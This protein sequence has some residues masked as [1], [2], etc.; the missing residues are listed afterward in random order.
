MFVTKNQIEERKA[1]MPRTR[2]YLATVYVRFDNAEREAQA[3][4]S[5]IEINVEQR[6]G[7]VGFF[8]DATQAGE[9]RTLVRELQQLDAE[10]HAEGK[11]D[12]IS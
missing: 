11:R 7:V 6:G 2:S 10:T 5:S 8:L 9:A 12:A 1:Q 3:D 4:S